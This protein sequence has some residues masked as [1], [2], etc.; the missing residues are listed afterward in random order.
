MLLWYYTVPPLVLY[1]HVLG[2]DMARLFL[3]LPVLLMLLSQTVEVSAS[4]WLIVEDGKPVKVEQLP[5]AWQ[6]RDAALIGERM[7]QFLFGTIKLLEGDVSVKLRMSIDQFDG[8]ATALIL[9]ANNYVGF[10]SRNGSIFLEGP[11]FTDSGTRKI[12]SRDET[13]QE[14]EPFDFE[15]K[16]Q[17][18]ELHFYINGKLL[19][20]QSDPAKLFGTIGVR[21]HRAKIAVYQFSAEGK[22]QTLPKDHDYMKPSVSFD[23]PDMTSLQPQPGVETAV[24]WESEIDGYNTYRIPSVIMTTKGTI[25]AFCEG[26][27]KSRSDTGNIDLMIK[28][29]KDNGRTWSE[30]AVLWDDAGNTCGN[31]CP[32]ID[33][34]SGDIVL[35]MTHNPG[36]EH[37]KEI[38][39]GSVAQGRTVWVSR[40][41]DDGVT[42][43]AP[44]NITDQAKDPAWGWYA[45]GPGVGIQ[46]THEPHAGRLVI[47]ANHSIKMK[48]DGETIN[49]NGAHTIYS[50][51]GGKTWNM[52]AP[53]RPSCNESQIVELSDGRLMLNSR[54]YTDP[55]L[56]RISFSNDGGETWSRPRIESQLIEP[57]CQ[58]SMI[59]FDPGE[60]SAKPWILFS[61][62]ATQ[63][64]RYNL[65]VRASSDDGQT[66][67]LTK[68]LE[69]GYAAYSC[70][71]QL[72]DDTVGCLYEGSKPGRPYQWIAFA[73][74]KWDWLHDIP[75]DP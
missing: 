38:Q 3:C 17:N 41:S 1:P 20:S 30:Q 36:D 62:P 51:D 14:G 9:D 22:A 44:K 68:T 29:S 42:W 16:R 34:H 67:S 24:V 35:L 21:T 43:T 64:G 53:V 47:P 57:R 5:G 39:T 15:L 54:S 8:T 52:S 11:R 58:G 32:V 50:D 70:L 74:F 40:S 66:W 75:T 46:L 59:R 63:S 73:R 69:P 55:K 23:K 12:A 19:R 72:D 33:R 4:T 48:V 49:E 56:R 31:P 18:G 61:N 71:I 7:G 27:V 45:T 10:D 13:I 28:R 60:Q 37:E 25:L 2:D 6:Q 65:T 26:R